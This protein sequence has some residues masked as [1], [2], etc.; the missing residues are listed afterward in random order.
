ME[1]PSGAASSSSSSVE[2]VFHDDLEYEFV[3]EVERLSN[4]ELL[5]ASDADFEI[6]GNGDEQEEEE[7]EEEE[8]ESCSVDV[9]VPKDLR[10]KRVVA[11]PISSLVEE[12][13]DGPFDDVYLLQNQVENGF[14]YGCN[15]LEEDESD[16]DVVDDDDDG[17]ECDLD[18]E[19][20]PWSVSD[21]L[22]RQRMRKLGKRGFTR[23][24]N[25]KRSPF[26]F[27]KPG[28]VRGKH[29]LG[30]KHSS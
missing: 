27:T 7:E 11:M 3:E 18:D 2:F 19:L 30:L 21:K 12:R 4:W 29:G 20:V 5:D 14:A 13:I 8:G 22:G 1:A 25:S 16:D 9:R 26:L 6:D 24:Y 17:D 28:C 10:G 15:D 23:M